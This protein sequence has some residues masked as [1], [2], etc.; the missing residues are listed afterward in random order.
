MFIKKDNKNLHLIKFN[1]NRIKN[2]RKSILQF[3]TEPFDESTNK[4]INHL[5]G[6]V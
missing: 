1:K 5:F 3:I 2:K 6:G 4:K